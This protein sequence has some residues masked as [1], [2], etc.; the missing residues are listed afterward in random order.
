MSLGESIEIFDGR[1]P[2]IPDVAHHPVIGQR[3]PPGRE[4][5]V[6]VKHA[7]CTV[8]CHWMGIVRKT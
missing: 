2:V 1:R 5:F 7:S 3:S 6:Q 8:K 4:G